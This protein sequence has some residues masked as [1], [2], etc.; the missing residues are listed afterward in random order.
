MKRFVALPSRVVSSSD[1]H[2]RDSIA[3]CPWFNLVAAGVVD[4]SIKPNNE[5]RKKAGGSGM[6][7]WSRLGRRSFPFDSILQVI[8]EQ[9][10][11]SL[12][13]LNTM[14]GTVSDRQACWCP[15]PLSLSGGIL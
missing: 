2:V 11:G 3:Q 5:R 4:R 12:R 1:V 6:R 14:E 7:H 13:Y 8:S 10:Q 9:G 15:S